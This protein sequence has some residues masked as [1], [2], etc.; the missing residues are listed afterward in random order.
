MRLIPLAGFD[1]NL[2]PISPAQLARRQQ[3][4]AE[5]DRVAKLPAYVPGDD[6]VE[7]RPVRAA[8]AEGVAT[9]REIGI[10]CAVAAPVSLAIV[11][12]Q[13]L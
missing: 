5:M 9:L 11:L 7:L 10:A 1:A 3:I 13:L 2:R 6:P 4:A 8:M 12:A